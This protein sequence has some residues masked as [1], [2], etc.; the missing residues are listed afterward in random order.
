MKPPQWFVRAIGMLDPLLSVR[1]SVSSNHWVIERKA[2][3]PISEIEVL[4]RRESRIWRWVSNPVGDDQRN[5]IHK[6][7]IA[8]QS[9]RDEVVSAQAGKRVISRPRVLTQEVYNDLCKS[10]LQRYGGFA[11]FCND[12]E[13]AEERAEADGERQL[14]NKRQ[15]MSGEVF[16]ILNFLERK[17]TEAM[18]HGHR[19]MSY[20][21]HGKHSKPGDAPLIQLNEF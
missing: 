9:L 1:R 3:V 16:S 10:D 4:Q 18:N 6:N 15:A 13:T 17:R 11:R 19:D 12:I 20:L 7:R 2:V 14:S 5:Q 8:W 21:L